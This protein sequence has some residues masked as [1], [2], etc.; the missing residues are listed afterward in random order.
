MTM[1][2]DLSRDTDEVKPGVLALRRARHQHPESAG[3][4]VWTAATLAEP[5]RA[6][7]SSPSW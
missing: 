2:V 4:E 3:E 6:G 7:S 1:R 5:W